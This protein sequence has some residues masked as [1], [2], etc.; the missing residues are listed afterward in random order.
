MPDTRF[1]HKAEVAVL[2][3]PFWRI[4]ENDQETT[5]P[6]SGAI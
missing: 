2:R 1:L 3:D 5:S 6:T 4:L